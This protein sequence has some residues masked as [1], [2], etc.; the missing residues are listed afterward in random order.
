MFIPSSPSWPTRHAGARLPGWPRTPPL[1]T[2][3]HTHTAVCPDLHT[4]TTPPNTT[5][6]PLFPPSPPLLQNTRVFSSR[7]QKVPVALRHSAADGRCGGGKGPW[8]LRLPVGC[9]AASPGG[10]P[11]LA[12]CRQQV[13]VPGWAAASPHLLFGQ[14]TTCYSSSRERK[15]PNTPCETPPRL[16][17]SL[18]LTLA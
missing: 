17:L 5:H 7:H 8:L 16:Q 11:G 12:V 13:F 18:A 3:T 10:G 15:Q 14:H 1:N 6:C 4:Q 2:T 9:P